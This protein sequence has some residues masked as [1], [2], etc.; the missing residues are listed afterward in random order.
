M[1]K[2]VLSL[3]LI[4]CLLLSCVVNKRNYTGNGVL[5]DKVK[6]RINYHGEVLK[7]KGRISIFAYS[8]S[9]VRFRFFGPMGFEVLHGTYGNSL[10]Y[11]SNI[12]KQEYDNVEKSIYETYHFRIDR[13]CFTLFLIGDTEGLRHELSIIN[14]ENSEI[15]ILG[16]DNDLSIVNTINSEYF[17]VSYVLKNFFPKTI[18]ISLGDRS[19]EKIKLLLEY[20][21]YRIL[22]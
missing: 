16:T 19:G 3:S 17:K 12:E 5:I 20:Y 18:S 9:L 2:K 11:F 15:Q 21:S 6:L 13:K 7:A 10:D 4:C 1:I 8:D 14:K 22:I